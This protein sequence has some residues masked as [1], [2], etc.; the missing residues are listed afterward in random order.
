[1]VRYLQGHQRLAWV[2]PCA[3]SPSSVPPLLGVLTD[4]DWASCPETRRSTSGGMIRY[5]RHWI[6]FWCRLQN[7][8]ALSS[9]EAELSSLLKGCSEGILLKNVLEEM[10]QQVHLEAFCDSSSA[11]GISN[12]EGVGK[13]KH[14]HIKHL[15]SQERV[16]NGELTIKRIPRKDNPSDALTH[17]LSGVELKTVM[18]KLGMLP[19]VGD[20]P[21][22]R[23]GFA[24]SNYD[25]H[26]VVSQHS[27][28]ALIRSQLGWHHRCGSGPARSPLD[29]R[30][31]SLLV[32][33]ITNLIIASSE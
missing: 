21:G 20:G 28:S 17:K 32:L 4:S 16:K 23:R 10:N 29:A 24:V 2:F 5:G 18:D 30:H 6:S 14:L 7:N 22:K 8:I 15:W 25:I 26:H 12:R 3:D 27:P 1:M 33:S 31:P 13:V 9:G 11:R 19:A